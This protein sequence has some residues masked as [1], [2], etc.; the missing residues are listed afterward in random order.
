LTLLF[1]IPA[2][3]FGVITVGSFVFHVLGYDAA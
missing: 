3:G 1:L 2:L